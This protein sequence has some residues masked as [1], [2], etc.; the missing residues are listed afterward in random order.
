MRVRWRRIGLGIVAALVLLAATVVGLWGGLLF[1]SDAADEYRGLNLHF[2]LFVS[3]ARS[4]TH[5]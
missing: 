1:T 2:G 5:L 4:T 3:N